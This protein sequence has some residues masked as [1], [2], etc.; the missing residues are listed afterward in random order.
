MTSQIQHLYKFIIGVLLF[1][2]GPWRLTIF[3]LQLIHLLFHFSVEEIVVG[4]TT[5]LCMEDND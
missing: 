4:V 1:S 3:F 2:I 5:T